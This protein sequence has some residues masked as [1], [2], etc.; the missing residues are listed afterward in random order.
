M[1]ESHET[2]FINVTQSA[3]S[4][5]RLLI[6]VGDAYVMTL[7]VWAYDPHAE[8]L[9]D[10]QRRGV[11]RIARIFEAAGLQDH[12]E[13]RVI[14]DNE[15]FELVQAGHTGPPRHIEVPAPAPPGPPPV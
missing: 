2:G 10:Q 14:P 13:A 8:G 1:P 3:L 5:P 4:W 9:T 11:S 15:F 7:A 12:V 6:K